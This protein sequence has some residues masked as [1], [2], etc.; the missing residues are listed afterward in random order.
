MLRTSL[1]ALAL[2]SLVPLSG[3]ASEA[4][5]ASPAVQKAIE[6]LRHANGRWSAVTEFLNP[7]GTVARSAHGTY[8]FAWIAP[9]RILSGHSEIPELQLKSGILFYVI[10]AKSAIE[11]VSVGRDGNLWVMTGPADS[12]IRTTPVIKM[13][14]G[15]TMQLRFTRYNVSPDRF[16][17]RMEYSTD[18]GA[19]WKPGNHQVM[20]RLK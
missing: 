16:E 2:L 11:M 7:D 10:E 17:S 12:E 14:D 1:F 6:Q 20:T 5:Q 15:S 19:T 18:G 4:P 3:A 8:E 9:D 13:S